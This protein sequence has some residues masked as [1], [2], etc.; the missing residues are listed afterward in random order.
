[1][2]KSLEYNSLMW[3]LIRGCFIGVSLNNI[4]FV[5]KQ[6]STLSILLASIIGIIFLFLYF[7][8]RNYKI[9]L[10]LFE[11]INSLFGKCGI[12]LNILCI[13]LAFIFS[14]MI[15]SDLTHFISSQFLYYTSSTVISIS[16]MILIVYALSKNIKTISKMSLIVF[17]ICLFISILIMI[18]LLFN[19]DISNFM[20]ILNDG[21]SPILKSSTIIL[22]YNI[23]P[24]FFLLVIPKKNIK[25]DSTKMSILFYIIS[26]FSIFSVTF[27]TISIFGVNLSLLYEY[28]G[29]HLLRQVNIGEFVDRIEIFLSIEWIISMCIMLI[30]CL[31]FANTGIK[32]II[33]VNKKWLILEA[34]V[35]IFLQSF[36]INNFLKAPVQ[37]HNIVLY[38]FLG[39]FIFL[40]FII[41]IKILFNNSKV[42]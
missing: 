16:F 28:P 37:E 36:V 34:T 2:I 40:Y 38:S 13:I 18:G 12:I 32:S 14:V 31:Y 4:I 30:L 9:E 23:L 26:L 17:F 8:I 24:I 3:F 33:K 1:M 10:N 5:S 29:F 7:Y 39:V 22:V 42:T 27:M 20:P 25:N 35:L 6:D 21:L 11:K 19:I 41:S 15:L